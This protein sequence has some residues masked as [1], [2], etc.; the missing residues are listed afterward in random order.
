M[1]INFEDIMFSKQKSIKSSRSASY[2]DDIRKNRHILGNVI[3]IILLFGRQNIPL[4]GH[5]EDKS[6]FMSILHTIAKTDEILADHL[7]NENARVKYTSPT[8]QN[9]L[10]DLCESQILKTIR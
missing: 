4:R 5:T 7:A 2:E 3:E 10:M 9:E 8:V 6:N 1:G